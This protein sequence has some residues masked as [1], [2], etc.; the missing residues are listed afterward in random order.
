MINFNILYKKEKLKHITDNYKIWK[1]SEKELLNL[2]PQII[3]LRKGGLSYPKIAKEL[4]IS[5]SAAW[6]HSKHIK[7]AELE[8]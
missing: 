1:T 2:K 6:N 8:G 4:N 3:E 7:V 5:T